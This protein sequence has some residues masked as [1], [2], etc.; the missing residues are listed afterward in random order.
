MSKLKTIPAYL[1][2]FLF[3]FSSI[4]FFYPIVPTPKLSGN[5]LVFFNLFGDTGYMA[6][7]KVFEIIGS[8]LILI[9]SKR[10]LAALILTPIAVNI[11]LFEVLVVGAPG[12]GV[13]VFVL[14]LYVIYQEK[15]TFKTLL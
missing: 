8:I 3:I 11:L 2:A 14:L 9:P 10:A 6:V 5:T 7:V 15:N 4:N 12:I 1:L 13:A